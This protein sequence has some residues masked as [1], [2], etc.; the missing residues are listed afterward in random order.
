M[1]QR[2]S[3]VVLGSVNID[4]TV[5]G[6]R[7][8]RPGETVLGGSFYRSQGGKGANQAVAAARAG[9][10]RIVLLAAVGNDAF[11]RESLDYYANEGIDCA[12]VRTVPDATTGVALIMVDEQGENCIS[13]ASG[14]NQRFAP[15][16]VDSLP[17]NVF[18]DA[19]VVLA[20]LESP[21]ESVREAIQ[22]AKDAGAITVL[23]PAPVPRDSSAIVNELLPYVDIIVPNR[24]EASALTGCD[25]PH[26]AS[27]WLAQ[28]N[29]RS[30][31]TLGSQG[32]LVYEDAVV[33]VS[34][35][36]VE[37]VDATGAGDALCGALAVAL[38]EGRSL[39][40][41]ARWANVAASLSVQRLGAGPSF[42]IRA[43]IDA[44]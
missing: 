41:A 22:R 18:A 34:A 11:S 32:C 13:V 12:H 31:I 14:A 35:H 17:E 29:C 16:D 26:A 15:T 23:N 10:H 24:G 20:C 9:E 40:D 42:P 27:E 3:I 28:R 4:L 6:P 5:R 25:T 2:N 8:P 30:V 21:I 39:V 44:A 7:L 37:A 19:A 43:E 33:D 1:S 36:E 38:A